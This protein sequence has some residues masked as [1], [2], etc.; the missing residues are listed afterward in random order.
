LLI[1]AWTERKRCT[2]PA[3]PNLLMWRSRYRVGCGDTSA[4]NALSMPN[5][6]GKSLTEL[7]APL[8]DSL[9]GH[10]NASSRKRF[11]DITE[12]QRKTEIQPDGVIDDRGEIAMAGVRIG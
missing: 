2:C 8:S 4:R 6:V 9:I 10:H 3:D 12:T 7:E 5:L 11:F 1:G